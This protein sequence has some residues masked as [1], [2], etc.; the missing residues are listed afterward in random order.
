MTKHPLFPYPSP[1][2]REERLDQ[3]AGA[4]GAEVRVIGESVEG[5]PIRAARIPRKATKAEEPSHPGECPR[6]LVCGNIHGLEWISSLASLGFVAAMERPR[7]AL[8]ALMERAEIWVVPCVN[9]D[10]YARVW[11]REGEGKL[12]ELRSNAR[13]VDL[14]RNYPLPAPQP[15]YAIKTGGWMTGSTDPTSP[16]FRGAGPLSEPETRAM[17][18]LFEEVPFAASVSLHSTMGALLSAHVERKDHLSGYGRLCRAFGEAQKVSRYRW[19][20]SRRLDWFT[21]EQEDHQHHRYGTWAICV[22]MFPI[23]ESLR[24]HLRAPSLF[25]RFNPREP[26]KW[27]ENDIP[28]MVAYFHAALDEGPPAP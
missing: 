4:V 17:A 10:G 28:G 25:W 8:R 24:Q 21:G 18:T 20:A 6:L 1:E 11:E 14:N 16:F 15:W 13:G 27:L 7:P 3:A 19:V 2:V 12:H 26:R 5:R 22:E 23:M 9:P